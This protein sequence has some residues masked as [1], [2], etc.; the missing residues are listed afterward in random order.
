MPTDKPA[1]A[2]F[3]FRHTGPQPTVPEIARHYDLGPDEIDSAYGVVPTDSQDHLYVV[4]VAPTGFDRLRRRL[5]DL[6]LEGD[7]AVGL[8]ADPPAEAFDC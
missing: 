8:F 5:R 6:G 4:L 7:P 3:Q 1:A 2:M